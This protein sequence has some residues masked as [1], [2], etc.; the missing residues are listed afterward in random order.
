MTIGCC[1]KAAEIK[2]ECKQA[3]QHREGDGEPAIHGLF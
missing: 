2:E 1:G 3:S